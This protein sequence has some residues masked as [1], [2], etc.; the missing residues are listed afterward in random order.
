[1]QF[2][3]LLSVAL[4]VLCV[5]DTAAIFQCEDKGEHCPAMIKRWEE[6]TSK[7]DS[8]HQVP[9]EFKNDWDK[10]NVDANNKFVSYVVCMMTEMGVAAIRSQ[11]TKPCRPFSTASV[12]R[13]RTS[14]LRVC[15]EDATNE[16]MNDEPLSQKVI[17]LH[18]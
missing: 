9:P 4:A 5:Q 12:G 2:T 11:Q 16:S 3:V 18:D 13:K 6:G 17:T 1:M 7:C 10:C 8:E 15:R 14:G